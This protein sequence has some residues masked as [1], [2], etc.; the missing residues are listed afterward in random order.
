MPV[1]VG[2]VERTP[3]QPLKTFLRGLAFP[4]YQVRDRLGRS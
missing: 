4:V 2:P 1:R 3:M